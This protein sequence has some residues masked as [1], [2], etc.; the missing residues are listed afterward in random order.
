VIGLSAWFRVELLKC[1]YDPVNSRDVTFRCTALD[2]C[3]DD[4]ASLVGFGQ[5]KCRYL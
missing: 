1:A 3:R 2:V 4:I 5:F